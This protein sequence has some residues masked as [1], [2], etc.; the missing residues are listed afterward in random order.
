MLCSD[1]LELTIPI[2]RSPVYAVLA[3]MAMNDGILCEGGAMIGGHA[4]VYSLRYHPENLLKPT[5]MLHAIVFE[6][7]NLIK[8]IGRGYELTEKGKRVSRAAYIPGDF[9]AWQGP[10]KIL[11]EKPNPVNL[12]VAIFMKKHGSMD[13]PTLEQGLGRV[14]SDAGYPSGL[15]VSLRRALGRRVVDFKQSVKFLAEGGFLNEDDGDIKKPSFERGRILSTDDYRYHLEFESVKKVAELL[16]DE[17]FMPA[18]DG[19]VPAVA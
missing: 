8:D 17:N 15:R 6:E 11:G 1:F 12:D 14:Y 19:R 3:N 2:E 4:A 5:S 18:E 9:S 16:D 13:Y 10:V 7:M